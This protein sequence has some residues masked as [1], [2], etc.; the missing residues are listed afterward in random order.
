MSQTEGSVLTGKDNLRGVRIMARISAEL[1]EKLQSAR[2]AQVQLIIRTTDDPGQYVTLLEERGIEVQQR[3]RL[4][5]RL[6]VQGP[7]DACLSL[8]SEPWVEAIEE[9][10]PVHTWTA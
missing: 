4:T 8:V 5:N 2:E 3:Y 6:A 9:D 7:A 1:L 10:R